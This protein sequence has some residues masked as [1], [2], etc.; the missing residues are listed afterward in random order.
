MTGST[1]LITVFI[2]MFTLILLVSD[3]SLSHERVRV[4]IKTDEYFDERVFASNDVR[5]LKRGQLMPIVVAEVPKDAVRRMRGARGILSI[6]KD[7][8]VKIPVEISRS[9]R[10]VPPGQ[11]IPWGIL[12]IK[13][14][15]AWNYGYSPSGVIEVAVL[16]TGIDYDHPDLAGTVVWGI[17]ILNGFVSTNPLFYKDYNG[18]GTHVA[19]VISALN[20]SFGVVG[21]APGIELYA[22]RVIDNTGSGWVSDIILGIEKALL[23]PDGILDKDG[24]GIV[25]GDPDDDAAE[26]IS[27]SFGSPSHVQAFHDVIVM[28]YN[29][30]VVFVAA[31]GN[32]SAST[33]DYPAAYP[34]VI[35]VGAVDSSDYVAFFS[36]QGVEL[37]APG[38]NILS[39]YLRNRYAILSGTSMST[40]HVSGLVALMQSVHYSIYGTVLPVGTETDTSNTTVRGI[41]HITADDMGSPG[42]DSDYGYGIIRAD[43]AVFEASN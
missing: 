26:V 5:I 17:S 1:K 43:L 3:I 40:P 9:R 18:H 28:A 14:P 32:E 33:P 38:I 12:R 37:T 7:V 4:I 22:V 27:M 24:D 30:G 19:G 2:S 25:V 10:R 29:L 39:T 20:N 8:K 36:N 31:A 6:E 15:D 41:L 11:I 35:A 34:E 21:V 13:A 16:D 23:G 42:Y